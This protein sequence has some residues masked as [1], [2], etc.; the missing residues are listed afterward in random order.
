MYSH[1]IQKQIFEITCSKESL[2]FEITQQASNL[3]K[4]RL[5]RLTQNIL[6]E[7]GSRATFVKI[8]KLALDLGELRLENWENELVFRYEQA[9]RKELKKI[10]ADNKVFS[11]QQTQHIQA[12]GSS[13]LALLEF[14]LQKGYLAWWCES[15][16]QNEMGIAQP[17]SLKALL[18]HLAKN[19]RKSLA[20]WL[21][22]QAENHP[23]VVRLQA[24]ITTHDFREI[25]FALLP[26]HIAQELVKMKQDLKTLFE[27]AFAD[28]LPL[29]RT[30]RMRLLQI[31]LEQEKNSHFFRE[32]TWF[33]L[34]IQKSLSPQQQNIFWETLS[35]IQTKKDKRLRSRLLDISGQARGALSKQ[36]QSHLLKM[37]WKN[38]THWE[39]LTAWLKPK[40]SNLFWKTIFPSQH[41]SIKQVITLFANLDWQVA[42]LKPITT[43]LAD[44]TTLQ[45]QAY[46]LAI[47]WENKSKTLPKEELINLLL[48]EVG[49]TLSDEQQD[50]L[51]TQIVAKT[52]PSIYLMTQRH[53]SGAD[54]PTQR[55]LAEWEAYL[56]QQGLG[57]AALQHLGSANA[58]FVLRYLTTLAALQ[59]ER[60]P[61]ELWA[62]ALMILQ[63]QPRLALE[64]FV[65][66]HLRMT[67][68]SHPDELVEQLVAQLPVLS[69]FQLT[70]KA[71]VAQPATLAALFNQ[72]VPSVETLLFW[73]L[74]GKDLPLAVQLRILFSEK[75][76]DRVHLETTLLDWVIQ[77]PQK[78]EGLAIKLGAANIYFANATFSFFSENFR[79]TLLQKI[80]S[81]FPTFE[82]DLPDYLLNSNLLNNFFKKQSAQQVIFN[83]MAFIYQP[84]FNLKDIDTFLDNASLPLAQK[85]ALEALLQKTNPLSKEA[86][87]Q[88][89]LEALQEDL[90]K[91]LPTRVEKLVVLLNL[92]LKSGAILQAL[93]INLQTFDSKVRQLLEKTLQSAVLEHF[94][95][96]FPRE[97]YFWVEALSVDERE[98]V[99]KINATLITKTLKNIAQNQQKVHLEKIKKTLAKQGLKPKTLEPINEVYVQNIGLVLLHPFLSRLFSRLGYLENREFKSLQTAERGVHLLHYLAYK[100][101]QPEEYVLSLNKL[102]CGLPL[103]AL[104]EKQLLLT[105]EEKEMAESLLVG[106][107]QNWPILK[108]T[109]PDGLRA[110]FLMR[111]GKMSEYEQHWQ[112][113]VAPKGID[114]LLGQLP[115]GLSTF[116]LNWMEKIFQ[117]D[118]QMP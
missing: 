70:G 58:T 116:K 28:A 4:S 81:I 103:D 52:P 36:Q 113:Q 29:L 10:I 98:K 72:P 42:K 73:L 91:I 87:R 27:Q 112:I 57:M 41:T 56:R 54:M 12:L 105:Q 3:L 67:A 99:A 15:S 84:D 18:I 46:L 31:V 117:V 50:S 34:L 92:Y 49:R 23:L 94:E 69:N 118:W 47:L 79:K 83:L 68:P 16:W 17:F 59:S 19:Q 55:S 40:N 80:Q 32:S 25:I 93:P 109:S 45:I 111:E 8:E 101:E 66:Q 11:P 100:T 96:K 65:Q 9:L 26:G 75:E 97:F 5:F 1:H 106:V 39:M 7:L 77:N 38:A 85:K 6:E 51:F 86:L 114:V 104:I 63:N 53:K 13:L 22:A 48:E 37:Q 35:Q 43:R 115:W 21:N 14:Y 30:M 20:E 44:T 108:N 64:L 82:K 90:M 71:K 33:T 61:I 88:A 76:K 74:G 107:I 78:F 102:L 95:R 60:T 24:Q 110:S 2:G 62:N 89:A